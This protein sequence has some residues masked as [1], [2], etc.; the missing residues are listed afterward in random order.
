MTLIVASKQILKVS[1]ESNTFFRNLHNRAF[2]ICAG[3]SSYS[4]EGREFVD[5]S[6]L[7]ECAACITHSF[8]LIRI[9]RFI[10]FLL[11]PMIPCSTILRHNINL[12]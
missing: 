6:W 9:I 10:L 7:Q 11:L 12:S 4:E 5:N 3:S 8:V 2:R 1:C